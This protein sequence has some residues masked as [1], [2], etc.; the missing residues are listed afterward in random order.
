[1]LIHKLHIQEWNHILSN[2]KQDLHRFNDRYQYNVADYNKLKNI[3]EKLNVFHSYLKNVNEHILV[4]GNK[5]SQIKKQVLAKELN[6]TFSD[7]QLTESKDY[8]QKF[9]PQ[10]LK[11][12]G[13]IEYLF[14]NLQEHLTSLAEKLHDNTFQ[15]EIDVSKKLIDQ[16]LQSLIS[17]QNVSSVLAKDLKTR[18]K[19]IQLEMATLKEEDNLIHHLDHN[20]ESWFMH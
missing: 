16:L 7:A 13:L 17:I 9:V 11:D 14:K 2:L 3:L 1:M 6:H 12:I 20:I 5:L 4:E 10:L 18:H 8:F 19:D 15:S